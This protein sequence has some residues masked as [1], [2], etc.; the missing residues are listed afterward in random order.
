MKIAHTKL[1]VVAIAA[2]LLAASSISYHLRARQ[3]ERAF[4]FLDDIHEMKHFSLVCV[5]QQQQKCK[6]KNN[7]NFQRHSHKINARLVFPCVCMYVDFT[8]MCM[9]VCLFS[10]FFSFFSLSLCLHNV[11]MCIT[12]AM[13]NARLIGN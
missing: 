9:F 12:S 3:T 5:R 11:L 10:Y 2:R 6:P 7:H 13:I 8:S 4:I 1:I